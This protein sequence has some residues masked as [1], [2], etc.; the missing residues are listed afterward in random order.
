MKQRN[1]KAIGTIATVL[2]LIVYSLVAMAVGGQ[3][4]VGRGMAFELPYYVIAG[5]LW[6]PVVMVIIKWMAKP[7][8]LS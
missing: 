1:R 7:D 8:Q 3:L 5:A 6:L 4:V 2:F